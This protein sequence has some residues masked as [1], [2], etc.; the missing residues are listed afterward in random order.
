MLTGLTTR[1]TSLAQSPVIPLPGV[2]MIGDAIASAADFFGLAP[3]S[4]M[5][6]T[7]SKNALSGLARSAGRFA[8]QGV[9]LPSPCPIPV[10]MTQAAHLDF[11]SHRGE[12]RF[13][14]SL[15]MNTSYPP[16]QEL[17]PIIEARIGQTLNFFKLWDPAGEAHIT[18]IT[19]VE[20]YD[21][22]REHLSIDE[23]ERIALSHN[24]QGSTIE[25]LGIGH[26]KA[27]T[28]Q[29]QPDEQMGETFFI[30]VRS[31]N[32]LN[33]RRE[34]KRAFL[35][36]GGDPAKFDAENFY[37]HITIGYTG[38]H[39]LHITDGVIKDVVNSLDKR[40]KILLV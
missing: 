23:I 2:R 14:T 26:G 36:N 13:D 7:A 6:K 31:E 34:I 12:G 40:F 28:K 10:S 4:R 18:T 24:I 35:K 17:R 3:V 9:D 27:M 25:I 33:I 30:I 37:P 22:L 29:G 1:F 38:A 19:P 16:I 15:A 5:T 11:I 20:Y 32:L 8:A 39:D 21:V